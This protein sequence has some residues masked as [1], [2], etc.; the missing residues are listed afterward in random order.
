MPRISSTTASNSSTEG[1]YKVIYRSGSI[2]AL[3]LL[4]NIT[5]NFE[6]MIE[7]TAAGE[8]STL[9]PV[10][11][12]PSILAGY[13]A[14]RHIMLNLYAS[15]NTTV[16]ETAFGGGQSI[17]IAMIKPLSRGCVLLNSTEPFAAPV[18]DYGTFSHPADLDV[19]VAVLKKTRNFM[20]SPPMQELGAVEAFPGAGIASDEAIAEAIRGSASSTWAHLTL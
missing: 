2:V 3:L 12:D 15:S 19:A 5:S 4:R 6:Q 1:A 20:A 18:F 16:Q 10:D 8:L 14:Q 7:S 11:V 9:L 13:K 17:P